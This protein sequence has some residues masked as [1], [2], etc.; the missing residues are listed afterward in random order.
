M[1]DHLNDY[2]NA[3]SPVFVGE[4]RGYR[5]WQLGP[6]YSF[7]VHFGENLF[8]LS[9]VRAVKASVLMS[10]FS[11]TIWGNTLVANCEGG[12]RVTRD[13]SG[14]YVQED[15]SH[16][17]TASP[18]PECTCGIYAF[19][20]A[21]RASNYFGII[22]GAV[23][24]SGTIVPGTKGFR[25]ERARIEALTVLRNRFREPELLEET[26]RSKYHGVPIFSNWESLVKEFP[27]GDVPWRRDG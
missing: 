7:S 23:A 6:E 26:L 1:G 10:V 4:L 22:G 15:F 27:P 3:D 2:G 9:N 16:Q 24:A 12:K 20:K 13:P 18:H 21:S 5:T 25:A 11:S 14:F 17:E 8:H 19:Y